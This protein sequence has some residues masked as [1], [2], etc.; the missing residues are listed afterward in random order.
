[1]TARRFT[2]LAVAVLIAPLRSAT[3][4][5]PGKAEQH[6]KDEEEQEVPAVQLEEEEDVSRPV[7]Q[8]R[9][10]AFVQRQVP[11]AN[12]QLQKSR[13]PLKASAA[14]LQKK[15]QEEAQEEQAPEP[16]APADP[17]QDDQ[18]QDDQQQ[19]QA[20]PKKDDQQQADN[21]NG[22]DADATDAGALTGTKAYHLTPDGA[23]TCDFGVTVTETK[24]KSVGEA[25]LQDMKI[26]PGR[27]YL[28]SGKMANAPPG[29]SIHT[30][31][32]FAVTYNTNTE[33]DNDGSF[34]SV[35]HGKKEEVH[36]V[37]EGETECDFGD[38]V[39]VDKCLDA[40]NSVLHTIAGETTKDQKT[41]NVGHWNTLP[42]GCSMHV[43]A[44]SKEALEGEDK[45]AFFNTKADA[46]NDGSYV[47]VC[48]GT[49]VPVR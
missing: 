23:K 31:M 29:C 7:H 28:V 10:Q 33:G 12:K 6:R 19:Q 44:G 35:C 37:K 11:K 38:A 45:V 13:K 8:D 27:T 16:Q 49:V 40:I 30:G 20:D 43:G 24:C 26:K 15:A 4:A 25:I 9:R 39:K 5:R 1:M 32:D 41:V 2:C 42:P 48:T 34:A 14:V 3:A 18:Q 21:K 46:K 22:K 17:K 47:L 36:G